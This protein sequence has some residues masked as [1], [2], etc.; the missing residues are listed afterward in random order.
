[1]A[2]ELGPPGGKIPQVGTGV[3]QVGQ[4]IRGPEDSPKAT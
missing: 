1:M 4:S 3:T 2:L